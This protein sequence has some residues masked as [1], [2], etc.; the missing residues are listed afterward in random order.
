MKGVISKKNL[1]G[2]WKIY[3]GKATTEPTRGDRKICWSGIISKRSATMHIT[4]L[5]RPDEKQI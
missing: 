3:I 2:L 1:Y 4:T 5:D